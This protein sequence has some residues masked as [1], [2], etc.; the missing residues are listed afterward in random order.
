[1]AK[2]RKHANE[3]LLDCIYSFISFFFSFVFFCPTCVKYLKWDPLTDVV[4]EKAMRARRENAVKKS[5]TTRRRKNSIFRVRK[6]KPILPWYVFSSFS[7]SLFFL[8]SFHSWRILPKN[9][10]IIFQA[11]S[12]FTRSNSPRF[13]PSVK[14]CLIDNNV[15][16]SC[17]F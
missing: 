7:F 13:L 1:M 3:T 4:R 11:R 8:L 2:N 12:P 5:T 14:C 15:K 9:N 10:D 6:L 17:A 16:F